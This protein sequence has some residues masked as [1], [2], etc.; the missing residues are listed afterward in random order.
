LVLK[1]ANRQDAKAAKKKVFSLRRVDAE[2]KGFAI[3]P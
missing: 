2:E 3:P 1:N